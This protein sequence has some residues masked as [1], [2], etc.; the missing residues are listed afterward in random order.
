MSWRLHVTGGI[1]RRWRPSAPWNVAHFPVSDRLRRERVVEPRDAC[2]VAFALAEPRGE[3]RGAAEI[4]VHLAG[5]F[6]RTKVGESA[7]SQL[8]LLSRQ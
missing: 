7:Q 4:L 3:T 1:G 8:R 5:T 6:G 2:Y